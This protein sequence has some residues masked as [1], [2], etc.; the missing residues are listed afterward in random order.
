VSVST[1]PAASHH[2]TVTFRRIQT[3]DAGGERVLAVFCPRQAQAV[4]LTQCRSC[5]HC[6]GLCVDP[7][8]RNTFLRCTAEPHTEAPGGAPKAPGQPRPRAAGDT[9]GDIMTRNVRT[10]S[11]DTNVAEL[12]RI[13]LEES[14]SAVPVV[15]TSGKA[16][17]LVSKTDVLQRYHDQDDAEPGVTV[18]SDGQGDPAVVVEL[19]SPA[20]ATVRDIMTHI[21]FSLSQEAPISRAA[22]L[23]SYEGVHRLVVVSAGGHAVGIVSSLDILRWLA[24]GDGYIVPHQAPLDSAQPGQAAPTGSREESTS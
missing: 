10:V 13:F 22:A 24:R 4:A 17:G 11:P 8:D 12:T 18:V 14:I 20:S 6:Q 19:G 1:R 9:L 15:D 2:L 23:M 3:E 16:I 7:S 21:V 5:D